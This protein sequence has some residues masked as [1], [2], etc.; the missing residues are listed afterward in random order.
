MKNSKILVLI[1]F[2]FLFLPPYIGSRIILQITE[3]VSGGIRWDFGGFGIG[4]ASTKTWNLVAALRY[5]FSKRYQIGLGY[6]IYDTEY[7]KGSGND[8]L[9]LDGR[10]YGPKIGLTYHF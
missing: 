8:E 9:G 3:K 6:H 10:L 1:V 7:S 4:S 2:V 5:R